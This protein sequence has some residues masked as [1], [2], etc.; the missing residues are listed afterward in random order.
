MSQVI[1]GVHGLGN[2]PPKEI[3]E[4]WW[5]DSIREG[6]QLSGLSI[7]DFKFEL[8][9]W[10]D[11]FNDK[12]QDP[13][14]QDNSDPFFLDEPYTSTPKDYVSEDHKIRQK[15]LDVL[16]KQL[17]NIFLND[18]LSINFS[19]I[20]DAILHSYFKEL[21][22][23]YSKEFYN[24]KEANCLARDIIRRRMADTLQ[25]YMD[26]DILII[27]HSMGSIIAYDVLTFT[28]PEV[29][30]HTFITM[31]S[32]LGLPIIISKIA[33]ERNIKLPEFQKPKTP[34]GIVK[35]WYN[36]SDLEDKVAL[37]YDLTD[38]FEANLN[39]INVENEVV[40]NTYIFKENRNPHKSFGYLRTPQIISVISQF[41]IK[42]K[43]NFISKIWYKMYRGYIS[44]FYR[45]K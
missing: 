3:L 14:I 28:V 11:V 38:K 18:D 35:S 4:K 42:E 34:P 33:S 6:Y 20:T 41:L 9:Y 37:I 2:K 25:K 21:E 27:G 13:K 17:Y 10:A 32:P 23:Y 29:P 16:E 7:P 31:G 24:D 30:I 43:V 8:V 5:L 26:D 39:G 40:E 22:I 44:I 1:I 36:F 12:P 19:F 45:N 15:V